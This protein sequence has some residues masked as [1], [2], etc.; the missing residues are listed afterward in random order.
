MK[1]QYTKKQI[2]EAIAYWKK[3]LNEAKDPS[4]YESFDSLKKKLDAELAEMASTSRPDLERI[5]YVYDNYDEDGRLEYDLRDDGNHDFGWGLKL[6]GGGRLNDKVSSFYDACVS[7]VQGD[8]P[9]TPMEFE[10]SFV[11]HPLN[12]LFLAA[13]EQDWKKAS[14][15]I[16]QD[17]SD[18]RMQR[19]F[20]D[21]VVADTDE[22]DGRTVEYYEYEI[23]LDWKEGL[24]ILREYAKKFY[25][26]WAKNFYKLDHKQFTVNYTA[27]HM[28]K[29]FAK[30]EAADEDEARRKFLGSHED[31]Y[32]MKD[33][34]ITSIEEN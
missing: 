26:V 3:R 5:K 33:Y 34:R 28:D 19:W 27:W 21:D 14:G 18:S 8:E 4:S 9:N 30:V 11:W 2:C 6:P 1:K 29:Y 17:L 12:S 13:I 25:D 31:E 20:D 22:E 32:D 16:A 7:L 23:R 10:D 15:V 24:A